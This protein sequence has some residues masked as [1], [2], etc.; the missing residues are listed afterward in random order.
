MTS[1]NLPGF[2]AEASLTR[3][4]QCYAAAWTSANHMSSG[5]IIPQFANCHSVDGDVCEYFCCSPNT[6]RCEYVDFC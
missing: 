1:Q 6:N 3:S 2:T 5:E 4:K